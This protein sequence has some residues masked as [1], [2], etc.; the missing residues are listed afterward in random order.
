[1]LP[2][3]GLW[4][5]EYPRRLGK[6]TRNRVLVG[7]SSCIPP[8]CLSSLLALVILKLLLKLIM[9]DSAVFVVQ[10]TRPSLDDPSLRM[11]LA[12]SFTKGSEISMNMAVRWMNQIGTTFGHVLLRHPI[13]DFSVLSLYPW[14]ATSFDDCQNFRRLTSSSA[15]FRALDARLGGRLFRHRE[16]RSAPSARPPS[17]STSL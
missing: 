10:C 14:T 11:A 1:M 17:C 7:G 9:Y 6:T 3:N 16:N 13:A 15:V 8:T 2:S 5:T 4:P 12:L